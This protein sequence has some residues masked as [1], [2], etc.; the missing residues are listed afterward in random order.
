MC[1][2]FKTIIFPHGGA[3]VASA[4]DLLGL[5]HVL[6]KT[7]H[8]SGVRPSLQS[9]IEPTGHASRRFVRSWKLGRSVPEMQM[10][11]ECALP[12]LEL[13]AQGPN[14]PNQSSMYLGFFRIQ[15]HLQRSC[16]D[17]ARQ[18]GEIADREAVCKAVPKK[19]KGGFNLGKSQG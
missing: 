9:M 17:S 19:P 13:E 4:F 5:G 16:V 1:R 3:G 14:F 11:T 18:V 6:Q 12:D 15:V 7:A 10:N 8:M 2:L